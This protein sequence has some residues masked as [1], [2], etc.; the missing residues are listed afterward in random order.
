MEL[1][2]RGTPATLAGIARDLGISK[3]AVSKAMRGHLDIGEDTRRRVMKRAGQLGYRANLTARSLRFSETLLIGIVVPTFAHSFFSELVE[4]A[5]AALERHGYQAIVTVSGENAAREV[6]QIEALIERQVDGLIVASSQRADAYGIFG[7]LEQR[8]LPFVL[9][10]RRVEGVAAA[11][12]GVDNFA[13]GRR[14]TEHLISRGR[15]RI[16]HLSG[17]RNTTGI[18]RCDGYMAAL[19]DAGLRVPSTYIAGGGDT[20]AVVE[21][22]TRKLLQ[23]GSRPDAI[24]CYNDQTA[25]A[26][27]RVIQASGLRV[28]EDIAIAGVGNIRYADRLPAPLTTI[29]QQPRAM[30]KT[31][32]TMLLAALAKGRMPAA[33]EVILP[34][35]LI[36]RESSGGNRLAEKMKSTTE[37][38]IHAKLSR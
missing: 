20:V 29:D 26:A 13:I 38:K 19:R 35:R 9:V 11:Y 33:R 27:L 1:R 3:M 32:T 18:L 22:A 6:R 23:C 25:A 12:A 37:R 28:P 14:M 30:G 36:I 10:G 24:F 8:Q 31:A 16:A 15:K 4:G 7:R 21:P 2:K 17:P 5:S 34:A